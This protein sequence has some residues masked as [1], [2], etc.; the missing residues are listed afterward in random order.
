MSAKHIAREPRPLTVAKGRC[1]IDTN[2][3]VYA[4]A[5]DEPLKQ[6]RALAL[7]G[8][9]HGLG[10]AVLSTQVLQEFCNVALKK[11]GMK[12]LQVQ[13]QLLFLR[14]LEVAVVSPDMLEQALDLHQQHQLSFYDA[15]IVS[16]A[17]ASRCTTLYSEDFQAGQ[18]LRGVKVVNPFTALT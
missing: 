6:A 11:L 3:L 7:L 18:V 13:T 14:Q 9:L 1:F 4:H 15:L 8:Q 5:N 17:Q 2:V 16:A 12:P 10:R